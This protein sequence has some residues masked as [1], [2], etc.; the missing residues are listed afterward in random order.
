MRL[1]LPLV[2]LLPVTASSQTL[3]YGWPGIGDDPCSEWLNCATGCSACNSPIASDASL[4]GTNASWMGVHYCP[5]PKGDG[6]SVVETS[7]WSELPGE[8]M[9]VFSLITLQPLQVDSIIIDHHGVDGGSTHLQVRYGVNTTLPVEVI[10]DEPVSMGE[11]RTV[12]ADAGCIIPAEGGAYGMAQ[13]IL[14]AYGG[15]GWLLD[16]VR[17]VTSPCMSTGIDVIVPTTAI[18]QRPVTDLFGRRVGDQASQGI[19][20]NARHQRVVVLP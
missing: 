11:Q 3:H 20:L 5:H 17:V 8:A 10:K 14:Q 19:Y 12:I 6:D 2:F 9:I 16:N 15:D 4:I 18:D 7:G 1:F 13:L